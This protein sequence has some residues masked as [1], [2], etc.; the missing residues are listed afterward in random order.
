MK[1]VKEE[2][3]IIIPE[4]EEKIIKTLLNKGK[5]INIYSNNKKEIIFKNGIKKEIYENGNQIIHFTNGDIKQIFPNEKIIYCCNQTKTIQI[6]F[7][8]GLQIFKFNNGQ[9]EKHFLDGSKQ[10]NQALYAYINTS[11]IFPSISI[12]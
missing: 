10:I 1:N 9:I 8:N 11:F 4:K 7:N 3:I 12:K 5:R 6:T 2:K